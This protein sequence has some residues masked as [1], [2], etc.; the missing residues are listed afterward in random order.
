MSETTV[1]LPADLSPLAF[2]IADELRVQRVPGQTP[3]GPH[4]VRQVLAALAER[5]SGP[6]YAAEPMVT[7]DAQGNLSYQIRDR[8]TGEVTAT[9]DGYFAG[10]DARSFAITLNKQEG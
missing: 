8:R 3:L 10:Q 5:A 9:Y 2:A 4:E 6:R 7:G 1:T